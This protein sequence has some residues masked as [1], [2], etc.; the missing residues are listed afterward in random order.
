MPVNLYNRYV[1]PHLINLSMGAEFLRDY[2]QRSVGN[3]RGCVLE[4]GVGSGINL[5]FYQAAQVERL[6]ALEPEAALLKLAR[7][8]FDEASFPI[9]VLETGAERIPLDDNT[10]DT[11]VSTWTLC[12]IADIEAAL[13]EARRV[14]A[15]GGRFVFVE[16][17]L[18]PEKRVALWQRRLT[19]CWRC[20]AGGCHL[21][22]QPDAL[23]RK[24][25]FQVET[26]NNA[27]LGHPKFLT[28][29]YEGQAHP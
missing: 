18:S 19:P 20:C 9:E 2:R 4:L 26:V 22:R 27:Y 12:S 21:D 13:V 8:R 28:Y 14:L 1:L 25:G 23:L 17:G 7:K 3:A 10:V 11:I 24:A 16:H 6:Y 15:P 29:M 5:P